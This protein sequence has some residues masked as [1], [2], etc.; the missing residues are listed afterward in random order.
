MLTLETNV[1]RAQVYRFL[2]DAFLYPTENWLDDA[3]ALEPIL[4]ALGMETPSVVTCDLPLATCDLL[5]AACNLRLATCDLQSEYRRALGVTGSVCY[6]TEY[7]LPHEFRQS[8]ELADIAG[9][10]N[11]FGFQ[12]GGAVRERPDHLAA[13]LEFMC[14]L[15][16]QEARARA[17]AEPE[18]TEICSDAQRKFLRDHL[19]RWIHLFAARVAQIASPG[20][21]QQLAAFTAAFVRA[22]AERLGAE[23]NACAPAQIFPTPPPQDIDCGGCPVLEYADTTY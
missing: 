4:R 1:R 16:L 2:A 11:A 13:E 5:L 22:D 20:I 8:Q 18:H 7:G 12:M 15:A 3:D 23:L 14:V 17:H 10:Y 19:G 21:Y 9:F 6:E